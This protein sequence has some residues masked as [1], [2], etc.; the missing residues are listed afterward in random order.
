MHLLSRL[1]QDDAG[2]DVVEYALIATLF[3]LVSMLA[4]GNFGIS[5]NSVWS[6]LNVSVAA[7]N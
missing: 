1:W 5:V 2:Q 6:A 7:A 3:S 4:I